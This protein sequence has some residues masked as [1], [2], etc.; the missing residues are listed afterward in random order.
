MGSNT[1]P[2][3]VLDI[4]DAEKEQSKA[5][6]HVFQSHQMSYNVI[7]SYTL[8]INITRVKGLCNWVII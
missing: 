5:H 1:D 8:R 4:E 3:H 7:V 2:G 6:R